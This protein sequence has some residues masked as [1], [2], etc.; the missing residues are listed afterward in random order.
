MGFKYYDTVNGAEWYRCDICNILTR[1]RPDVCPVCHNQ[2][3]PMQE[4]KNAEKVID[5]AIDKLKAIMEKY[6]GNI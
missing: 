4:D 1:G 5:N 2:G 6:G 3:E